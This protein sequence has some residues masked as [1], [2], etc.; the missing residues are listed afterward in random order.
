[1]I[2]STPSATVPGAAPGRPVIRTSSRRD[3]G[4]QPG[5]YVVE[6]VMRRRIRV[7]E[8]A[9][10]IDDQLADEPL[11]EEEAERVVHGRFRR[12]RM[13][14][15]YRRENLFRGQVLLAL[16]EHVRDLD[17]LARRRNSVRPQEIGQRFARNALKFHGFDGTANR[18]PLSSPTSTVRGCQ[19][20]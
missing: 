13:T 10:R 16:E 12:L 3:V 20:R 14:C 9:R 17:P 18:S 8:H 6:V 7:V 2:T 5:Y 19:S 11:L 15:I 4:E 1:M